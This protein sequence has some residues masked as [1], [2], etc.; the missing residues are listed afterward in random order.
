MKQIDLM[1]NSKK[2]E[3][4]RDLLT[5]KSRLDVREKEGLL[6]RATLDHKNKE[7]S[8]MLSLQQNFIVLASYNTSVAFE[9]EI[10]YTSNIFIT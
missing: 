7:V 9:N 1:V 2:Q 4:E 3:W 8:W 5:T 10:K 6:Q